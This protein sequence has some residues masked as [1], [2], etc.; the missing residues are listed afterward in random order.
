MQGSRS[1]LARESGGAGGETAAVAALIIDLASTLRNEMVADGI[2]SAEAFE[3]TMAA[4]LT[5][6][7]TT[8]CLGLTASSASWDHVDEHGAEAP[9]GAS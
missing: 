6:I 2:A 7:Q 4:L 9:F 8:G 3:E 5:E 1:S